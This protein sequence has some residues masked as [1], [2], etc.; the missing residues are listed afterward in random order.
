MSAHEDVGGRDETK[1]SSERS[2]AL[3]FAVV[4]GGLAPLNR[5]WARLGLVLRRLSNPLV[6]A[7]I[8]YLAVMP[9]ALVSPLAGK[10]PV[11][12][13]FAPEAASYR[14]ERRPPGPAPESMR[15]QF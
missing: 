2:F 15:H 6:M 7:V 4:L 14:I 8:F 11:R 10:D 13:R 1:A 12:R 5:A 9:T 3:V